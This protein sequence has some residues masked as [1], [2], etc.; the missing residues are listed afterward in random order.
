MLDPRPLQPE[1]TGLRVAIEGGLDAAEWADLEGRVR[2]ALRFLTAGWWQAWADALLPYDS[3]RGP[4]RYLVARDHL[5]MVQAVLPLAEQMMAGLS[6]LSLAGNYKPFRTLLIAET[7]PEDTADAL[8]RFLTDDLK[9]RAFRLGPVQADAPEVLAFIQALENAGWHFCRMHRG[10]EFLM[11]LEGDLEAYRAAV[12]T[13]KFQRI[14]YKKNRL[15]KQGALR[16]ER[17]Q[18]QSSE[19]WSEVITDAAQIESASWLRQDGGDPTFDEPA[20]A[21]FW[22]A[23]LGDARASAAASIWVLYLDDRPI[24][25]NAILDAGDHRYLMALAYDQAWRERSPGKILFLDSMTTAFEEGIGCYNMGQ[26][27]SGYKAEWG[28]ARIG[29]LD[30]WLILPPTASGRLLHLA[31][32][33]KFG[34][35]V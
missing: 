13:K 33:V 20:L 28:A 27:D 9:P 19:R 18:G 29:H 1:A 3:W 4:L 17:F 10:T 32:R 14:R 6:V 12:G 8:A 16:I 25:F 7:A 5:G 22:E 30:D 15:A 2:P 26:G 23:Y 31:A 34:K 11:D 35:V 21:A 24:S